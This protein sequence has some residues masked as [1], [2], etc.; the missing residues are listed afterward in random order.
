MPG[1]FVDATDEVTPEASAT[2]LRMAL[3]IAASLSQAT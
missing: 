2:L 1:L 3:D